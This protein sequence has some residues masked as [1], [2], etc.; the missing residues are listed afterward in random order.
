MSSACHSAWSEAQAQNPSMPFPF[1][2]FAVVVY[3]VEQQLNIF[4]ERA[5]TIPNLLGRSPLH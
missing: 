1:S 4:R 3:I 5:N 2:Y